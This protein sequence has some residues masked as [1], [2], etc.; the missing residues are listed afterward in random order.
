[1]HLTSEQIAMLARECE[2]PECGSTCG[3]VDNGASIFDALSLCC[4]ACGTHFDPIEQER[5]HDLLGLINR[6]QS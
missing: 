5:A 2:C 3:H 4:T 6:G 1:M